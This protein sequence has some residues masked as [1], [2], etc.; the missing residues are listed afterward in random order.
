M[1]PET[2][3]RVGVD[4]SA[5]PGGGPSRRV[6]LGRVPIVGAA[7]PIGVYVAP[8]TIAGQLVFK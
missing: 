4:A 7:P 2:Q 5:Q 8:G 6:I 1:C 3:P